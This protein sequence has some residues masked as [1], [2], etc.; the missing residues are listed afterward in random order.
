[1]RFALR[2]FQASAIRAIGRY[3]MVSLP[4]QG[5]LDTKLQKDSST[6][7]SMALRR[8]VSEYSFLA[9]GVPRRHFLTRLIFLMPLTRTH[10]ANLP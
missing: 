6:L 9:A 10:D 8:L 3:T 1:M 5:Q 7:P 2:M 4:L